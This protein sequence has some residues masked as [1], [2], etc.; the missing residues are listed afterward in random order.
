MGKKSKFGNLDGA[1]DGRRLAIERMGLFSELGYLKSPPLP[2][3]KKPQEIGKQFTTS[4]AKEGTY[5]S[6]EYARAFQGEG[7]SDL[8]LV[9]RQY[10]R[11]QSQRNLVPA[12]F[13]PSNV[14]PKAS[15]KGS[16]YGTIS[17]Q[18]PIKDSKSALPLAPEKETVVEP[19]LRNF[20]TSPPKYGGYGFVEGTI[21]KL[22]GYMSTPYNR[23]QELNVKAA[24]QS[25]KMCVDSKA[26]VGSSHEKPYF[27]NNP[28]VGAS[29]FTIGDKTK[30]KPPEV[31]WRPPS[32]SQPYLNTFPEYK[33]HNPHPAKTEIEAAVRE[34]VQAAKEHQ[35]D[36][37]ERF[38]PVGASCHSYPIKSIVE[39]NV[40]RAP[41]ARMRAMIH[42]LRHP[43]PAAGT[44][45]AG[46]GGG[47]SGAQGSVTL[48]P[49]PTKS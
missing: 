39:M 30:S 11:E 15:G 31:P 23:E 5:F 10:R 3:S 35:S 36:S 44:G 12:G 25:K 46:A 37:H 42:A 18:Y 43:A 26:F 9:R 24:E 1:E 34:K 38:R 29:P 47:G 33:A 20:Y 32:H 49:L 28:F 41:S 4:P 13:R 45:G 6:K 8:V 7:Y 22:P 16:I 19:S 2:P 48:A 27:D 14:P 21:G 40:P 17:Q